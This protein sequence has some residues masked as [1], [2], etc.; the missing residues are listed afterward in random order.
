MKP[1]FKKNRV[2]HMD[3]K[4]MSNSD[5]STTDSELTVY[6]MAQTGNLSHMCV[7]PKIEGIIEMELRHR[8]CSFSHFKRTV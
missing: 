6:I 2:H 4:D 3:A 5:G 8:C 7:K 1:K